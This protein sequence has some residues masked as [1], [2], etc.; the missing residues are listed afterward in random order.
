MSAASLLLLLLP[1]VSAQ[2]YHWGPCPT[3]KVQ[4]NF[5]LQQYLGRWYEIAR[6]PASF[7]RGTCIQANYALREDG[8]IRVLN[9]GLD[10]NKVRAVE[11]TAVVR[12]PREPAKLG[13]SFSYFS[14]YGQYWVLTS[15]YT[16]LSVVYSCTDILRIFH[17]DFAWILGRSRI[18]PPE[19]IR[20]AKNLMIGEGIDLSRMKFTNQTG[21][22]DD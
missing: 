7:E 9:S 1:L 8:T 18:L 13:V 4:P 6:L 2:T 22:R 14:P 11:G 3:A 5:N 12:D 15:D 17:I 20:Y 16:S 10:K 21:C 19:T